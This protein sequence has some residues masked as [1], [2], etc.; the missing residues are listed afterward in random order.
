MSLS[1]LQVSVSTARSQLWKSPALSV[2]IFAWE[3]DFCQ[4]MFLKAWLD[5]GTGVGTAQRGELSIPRKL[6]NLNIGVL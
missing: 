2:D 1:I 5:N 4:V 3:E 6:Q